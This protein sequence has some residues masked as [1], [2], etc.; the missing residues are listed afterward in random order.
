MQILDAHPD[1]CEQILALMPRLASFDLPD[2][3]NPRHLWSGD[4][5]MLKR[6]A[7]G[8]LD[9]CQ[10]SVAKDSADNVVGMAMVTMRQE[11]LSGNDSAHL[12]ALAVSQDAQG[13]GIGRKLL[14][15][16]EKRAIDAGAR[17]MSLHVFA[18]NE[19]ARYVYER[20]GFDGELVRYIKTYSSDAL[21]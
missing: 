7:D 6:W 1:D 9:L 15:H 10:V 21:S 16:A 19:R 11:L 20:A 3:R 8:D 14:Q 12:E 4:A 18:C 5:E 13:H 17:S 2:N